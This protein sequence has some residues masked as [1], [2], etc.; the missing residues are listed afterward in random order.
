MPAE[1]LVVGCEP[2]SKNFVA[3]TLGLGS[4][5]NEPR[6]KWTRGDNVTPR[7]V[8]LVRC[9]EVHDHE[10]VRLRCHALRLPILRQLDG[11]RRRLAGILILPRVPGVLIRRQARNLL[12]VRVPDLH[13]RAR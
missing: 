13:W 4:F 9:R 5:S 3:E 6:T 10:A 7:P 11:K 12:G 2:R 8:L 1:E